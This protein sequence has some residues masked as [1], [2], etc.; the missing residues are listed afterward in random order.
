MD[1]K[2]DY[3]DYMI[4]KIST[5]NL[6]HFD[7]IKESLERFKTKQVESIGKDLKP[8]HFHYYTNY[9]LDFLDYYNYYRCRELNL[10]I[11]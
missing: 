11:E 1:Y 10:E 9:K 5:L 3:I 7:I 6:K 2:V 4:S 8:I